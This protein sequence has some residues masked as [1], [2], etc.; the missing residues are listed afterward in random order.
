MLILQGVAAVEWL[1]RW[2]RDST[3]ARSIPAAATNPG[4][5]DRQWVGKP[6][7]YFTKPS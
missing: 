6:P 1:E 7:Q 2:T 3:V 4:T 5:G